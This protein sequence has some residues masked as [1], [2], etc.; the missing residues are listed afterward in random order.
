ML[1][2][3]LNRGLDSKRVYHSK[4]KFP[5]VLKF[6]NF[7]NFVCKKLCKLFQAYL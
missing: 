3:I 2:I 4:K 6:A 5:V 1:K 7:A